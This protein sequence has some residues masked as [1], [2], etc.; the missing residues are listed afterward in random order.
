MSEQSLRAGEQ[1]GLMKSSVTSFLSLDS[2]TFH[3]CGN[4]A[5]VG[6]GDRQCSSAT[7]GCGYPGNLLPSLGMQRL[8]LFK[9][10]ELKPADSIP[11][12]VCF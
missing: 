5:L 2:D 7:V 10:G 12:E 4:S 1:M 8:N 11:A 3:T 9:A 6:G